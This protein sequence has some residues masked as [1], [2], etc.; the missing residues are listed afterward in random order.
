VRVCEREES[1]WLLEKLEV[2]TRTSLEQE[3]IQYQPVLPR[4]GKIC[5]QS[6]WRNAE[7]PLEGRRSRENGGVEA[8]TREEGKRDSEHKRCRLAD[9]Q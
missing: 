8:G 9:L 5:S 7:E 2:T 4:I 6:P 3:S 1:A